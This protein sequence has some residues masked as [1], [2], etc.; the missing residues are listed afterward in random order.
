MSTGPEPPA[1]FGTAF[2]NT[3]V[4]VDFENGQWG[5]PD[6]TP[7]ESLSLHPGSHAL[8][9][10]S[11]CF[12]GLKAHQGVDGKVRVFRMDRNVERMQRSAQ[13]LHLP[14]PESGL[15][16]GMIRGVVA[17]NLEEVPKAPGSLYIRPTLIGTEV[18]I[19]AAAAPTQSA[20]LYVICC[21]V[22]GYFA[23][24][25]R[26]L[27]IAVEVDQP[28]T[29][30]QFGMVKSGANYAMAL[31]VIMGAREELG[32]DQVLFVPGGVVQE[33]GATNFLLIDSHRII[34]PALTESFLHGVTRDSLLRIG[35][36]L[37]YEI[38]ERELTLD[39]ILDWAS[40]PDAECALSG[41]AAVLA[42]VGTLVHKGE[43]LP[44]G[45][46]QPGPNTLRLRTALTDLQT[47]EAPDPYGWLTEIV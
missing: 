26:P 25:V 4:S 30:P 24:G 8:H 21:P 17:A 47:A 31:G 12:E 20:L 1:A 32:V 35:M 46:G 43:D 36:D 39:E 40:R 44:V 28:R 37:G 9:Y 2:A 16:T 7:V 3:M 13:V 22:G 19:G 41:T 10:G 34:T 42:P 33:T 11:A 6:L 18:N 38:E 14:V 27:R 45:S 15:L 29:T 5:T 23:G